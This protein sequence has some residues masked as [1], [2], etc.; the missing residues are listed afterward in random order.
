MKKDYLKLRPCFID[1]RLSQSPKQQQYQRINQTLQASL[2]AATLSWVIAPALRYSALHS[3]AMVA[4]FPAYAVSLGLDAYFELQEYQRIAEV[5][6]R[7]LN[8]WVKAKTTFAVLAAGVAGV[9]ITSWLL[10]SITAVAAAALPHLVIATMA[11]RSS[12]HLCRLILSYQRYQTLQ[13]QEERVKQR[14]A[15]VDESIK[16]SGSLLAVAAVVGLL[17]ATLPPALLIAIIAVT[18]T[19]FAGYALWRVSPKKWREQVKQRYALF[20]SAEPS[21]PCVTDDTFGL[22]AWNA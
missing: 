18:A 3:P 21:P 15:L 17:L 22:N 5:K 13:H 9:A 14:Q 8:P 12:Y 1:N 6:H 11:L 10:V 7:M 20:K 16:L 4:L 2:L 19:V